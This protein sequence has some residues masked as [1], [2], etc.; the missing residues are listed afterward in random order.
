MIITVT[1]GSSTVSTSCE[2]ATRLIPAAQ[3]V[4]GEITSVERMR[5]GEPG[6]HPWTVRAHLAA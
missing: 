3:T 6:G 2:M 4:L 5:A 1:S